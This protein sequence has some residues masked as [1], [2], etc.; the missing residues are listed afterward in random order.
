[1]TFVQFAFA[2]KHKTTNLELHK[3]SNISHII[4]GMELPEDVIKS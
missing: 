2:D 4:L 1:M 3:E